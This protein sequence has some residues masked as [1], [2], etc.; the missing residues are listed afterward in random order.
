MLTWDENK[1]QSNLNK[2]GIDFADLEHVFDF[3]MYTEEDSTVPHGEKRL[4][5]YCIYRGRVVVLIWIERAASAHII[6]CRYG[7]KHETRRY[8]ETF[9]FYFN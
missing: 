7:R 4:R 3:Q 8:S 5:S 6:S 9:P 2:H 1:R